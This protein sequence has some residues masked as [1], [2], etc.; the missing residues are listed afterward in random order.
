MKKFVSLVLCAA[1]LVSVCVSSATAVGAEEGVS[2]FNLDKIDPQMSLLDALEQ[3]PEIYDIFYIEKI[4]AE[5]AETRQAD[6]V[7]LINGNE[8]PAS[9]L[10][11]LN[12]RKVP[13][14]TALIRVSLKQNVSY[15]TACK[16]RDVFYFTQ[17]LPKYHHSGGCAPK[18]CGGRLSSLCY[19][20]GPACSPEQKR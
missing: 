17:I 16:I 9:I 15:F 4:T 2:T 7:R 3:Y 6:G 10:Y 5:Q 1:L 8:V 13:I 19:R 18:L 12:A 11:S 20:A 14:N